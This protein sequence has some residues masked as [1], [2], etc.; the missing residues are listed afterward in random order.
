MTEYET[1]EEA[2]NA[3]YEFNSAK[4]IQIT[5]METGKTRQATLEDIQSANMDILYQ[6]ADLLKINLSEVEA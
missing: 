2:L 6:L 5:D 4:E 3:L 1:V